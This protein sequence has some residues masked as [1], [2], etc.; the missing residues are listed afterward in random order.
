MCH[1][2]VAQWIVR[3]FPKR[4]VEGSS[5]FGEAN[6]STYMGVVRRPL[7]DEVVTDVGVRVPLLPPRFLTQEAKGSGCNPGVRRFE[8]DRNLQMI[9]PTH[10]SFSA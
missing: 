2:S 5:P 3:A 9:T 10:P 6:G 8:S 1:L 4:E 7:S